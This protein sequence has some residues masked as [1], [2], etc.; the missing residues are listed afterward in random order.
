MIDEKQKETL[1]TLTVEL[2]LDL[3][4]QYLRTPGCNA[5]THWE[6]LTTRMR[7]CARMSESVDEWATMMLRRLQIPAPSKYSSDSLLTLSHAVRELGAASDWL[8]LIERE[9]ALLIAIARKTSEERR[10][11]RASADETLTP[12]EV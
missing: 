6:Q 9:H 5:L 8:E 1:R 11:Q 7:A 3:R 12:Q 10:D 4:S 2:M